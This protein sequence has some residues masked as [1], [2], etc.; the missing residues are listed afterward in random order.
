MKYANKKLPTILFKPGKLLFL[1]LLVISTNRIW[2]NSVEKTGKLAVPFSTVTANPSSLSFDTVVGVGTVSSSKEVTITISGVSSTA[3][4]TIIASNN[5]NFGQLP[6]EDPIFNILTITG[7]ATVKLRVRFSGA[8]VAGTYNGLLTISGNEITTKTVPLSTTLVV[9]PTF[10]PAFLLFNT[11]ERALSDVQEFTFEVKDVPLG[12]QTFVTAPD[13]YALMV[14][15]TGVKGSVFTVTGNG[16]FKVLVQFLGS[17]TAGAFSSQLSITGSAVVLQTVPLTAKVT[18]NPSFFP[19]SLSFLSV[20]GQPSGLHELSMSVSNLSAGTQTIIQAPDG[21]S[22]FSSPNATAT[23]KLNFT[24]NGTFKFFVQ[25]DGGEILL[26]FVTKLTVTN[27]EFGTRI[28]LLKPDII[29]KLTPVINPATL[30]GF[31]AVQ[32]GALSAIQSFDVSVTGLPAQGAQPITITAPKGY[33][34]SSSGVTGSFF[35]SFILT[36]SNGSIK[37]KVFVALSSNNPVG[38]ISGNVT[39]TGS[40]INT[41]NVPVS[42]TITAKPQPTLTV[43]KTSLSGFTTFTNKASTTQSYNLKAANL[44]TGV[45]A[46]VIAP[47]GFEVSLSNTSGSV[48][49]NQLTVAQAA[50]NINVTVFVRLKSQ[51]ATGTKTG[52]IQNSVVGLSKSVAVSGIVTVSPTLSVTPPSLTG[53]NTVKDQASASKTYTFLAANLAAGVTATVSAPVNYEVRLQNT[54]SFASSLTLTQNST[55]AINRV[56]EVRLKATGLTGTVTGTIQNAVAGITKNVSVSGTVAA[57]T[58]SLSSTLLTGFST[59]PNQPSPTKP[60]TF[61]ASNLATGVTATV[62]APAGYELS[63]SGTTT[64]ASSLTLAPTNGAISKIILVRLKAQ[65]ATG[66]KSGNITHT[67][68]GLSKTVAV[69]GNVKAAAFTATIGAESKNEKEVAPRL[70]KAFPNPFH[71]QFFVEFE[72]PGNQFV[73]FRLLDLS[74]NQL[75]K[76]EVVSTGGIQRIKL[77]VGPQRKGIYLL[78]VVTESARQTIKLINQ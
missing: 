15:P 65:T 73:H 68:A 66:T 26:D 67:V 28:V 62:T 32:G 60:Y 44:A 21:F 20:A 71:S 13:G 47:T 7:N 19:S 29:A 10:N 23:Q 46:T 74:G 5:Y 35:N 4:T 53:F 1:L 34:V 57:P 51:A 25:F 14:S 8:D 41:K 43:D 56:V 6:A 12:S 59:V 11:V 17:P 54:G 30:S 2:A 31:T 64:F 77:P 63:L 69:S 9:K 40:Q 50:G 58:L 48:F 27:I 38:P 16:S 37:S 72:A 42:G 33:L 78:E 22:L 61:S 24:G 70:V 49:F 3:K 76:K 52:S 55:G 45:T 36:V 39:I 18:P 75:F